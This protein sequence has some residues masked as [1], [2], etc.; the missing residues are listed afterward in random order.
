MQPLRPPSR[1]QTEEGE[2][3]MR[4]R[5]GL[6]RLSLF[7]LTLTLAI[8]ASAAADESPSRKD[9]QMVAPGLDK[10]TQDRLLGEV[11]KRPGLSPRDRSIVTVAALIGRNQTDALADHLKLA[12]NHGVKPAELSEIITHLAFYSGW[13]NAISAIAIAKD[14]FAERNIGPDQLPAASPALLPLNEAAEADRAKRVGEQFG[15]MFP[16]VV[17]YT[18]DVLFRDLW[19]RPDLAPRDRS[20]VTISALIA[21]GQVAQ[22]T[23]HIPIGMNNG[24]TQLEIA[25]AITHLAFYVGWPNLFSAMPVAKEVFEKRAR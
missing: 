12:L 14:V 7:A 24:L 10:Y 25:E 1:T 8:P 22:L 17:Q 20:L 18:T 4:P 16:G 13:A 5:T 9:I 6:L 21:N 19:L 2:I 3:D 15:T 11:W 23:G